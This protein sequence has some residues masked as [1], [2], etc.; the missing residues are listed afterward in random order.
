MRIA[1]DTMGSDRGPQEIIAGALRWVE[2]KENNIFLVGPIQTIQEELEK[3][4]YDSSRVNIVEANQVIEMNESPALALRRKKDASIAVATK[5]VKDDIADAV[6]S[7]GSTGGQMAAAIFILGRIKGIQRPPIVADIPRIDDGYTLLM[8]VGANVDCKAEQLLQF[9]L[10]GNV[11]SKSILGVDNPRIALL[12]NGEEE[13]KG[14][15]LSLETYNLLREQNALNFIGNIEGRDILNPI[16]DVIICDG[17]VG[18]VV[19]KTIEGVVRLIAEGVNNEIGKIPDFFHK[20][21]Y[22]QV[23]GAPLLG[24]SGVS[25]VCHGSSSS[26]AVYNGLNVAQQCH[27]NK[28]VSL[29][30]EELLKLV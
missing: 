19:L 26:E 12:N 24:V 4:D 16:A 30:Q 2:G 13:N 1:I 23:G 20:L 29:Q 6:L 3:Y 18:N 5:L 14:N 17:F 25:I 28:L 15:N 10:L 11:Y 27:V 22:S 21:D 8:D 9:A 7:C